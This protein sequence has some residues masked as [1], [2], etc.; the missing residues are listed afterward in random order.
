MEQEQYWALQ[1]RQARDLLYEE[2]VVLR[3]RA[4][5]RLKLYSAPDGHLDP[6][7]PR[8]HPGGTFRICAL[9]T[10]SDGRRVC[11]QLNTNHWVNILVQ[12]NLQ[13]DFRPQWY[14][15]RT[16]MPAPQPK[17]ASHGRQRKRS[18]QDVD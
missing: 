5:F 7:M 14:V 3:K 2:V 9:A 1:Q 15:R 4:G 17:R 18:W 6:Q 11:A 12:Y 13:G 8:I 10:S 16:T